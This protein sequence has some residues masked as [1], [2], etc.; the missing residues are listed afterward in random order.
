M[1]TAKLIYWRKSDYAKEPEPRFVRE[2]AY[3]DT[4]RDTADGVETVEVPQKDALRLA[5]EIDRCATMDGKPFDA[6][7][8][9]GHGVTI[10][11]ASGR[12]R[13]VYAHDA[14]YY[15]GGRVIVSDPT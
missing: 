11:Y 12:T 2:A 13:T 6:G 10:R 5:A 1:K 14:D 8:R 3:R 7:A 9:P 4:D 15:N